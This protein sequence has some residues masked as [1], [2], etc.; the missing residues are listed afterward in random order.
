M[1]A[2]DDDFHLRMLHAAQKRGETATQPY[3]MHWGDPKEKAFLALVRDRWCANF[4]TPTRCCLEIGPGGGRW[5]RYLLGCDHLYAVD[6]HQELLDELRR[7]YPVPHLQTIKNAGTDFPGVPDGS[8]D[9][10]F[11]FGVFVHLELDAIRDY[12]VEIRRVLR[13]NGDVVI[14]YSDKSKKQAQKNNGFSDNTPS[15]MRRLLMDE[16]FVILAENL[17]VMP[18]AGIVH[19]THDAASPLMVNQT[20]TSA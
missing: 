19:F 16:G 12:L 1:P 7:N 20:Y 2:L 4:V 5:T 9:F 14:Q 17:T 11:S 15:R 3:G 6:C 18:H 13:P 10:I 8:V